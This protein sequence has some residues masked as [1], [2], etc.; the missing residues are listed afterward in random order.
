[1]ITFIIC[2]VAALIL[3]VRFVC[4]NWK[5]LTLGFCTL[6]IVLSLMMGVIA[7]G[8][9][10][11]IGGMVVYGFADK[12]WVVVKEYKL[13]SC[14]NSNAIS[15]YFFLGSGTIDSKDYYSAMCE[16]D[17][18]VMHSYRVLAEDSYIYYTENE[19]K[20]NIRANRVVKYEWLSK[21]FDVK[22]GEQIDYVF[23]IPKGS[24]RQVYKLN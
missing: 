20:L 16:Y 15:G 3:G 12:E 5:E 19:P 2:I 4:V 10:Y 7:V 23:Y 6:F 9:V 22:S 18:G 13:V 8:I 14:D 21:F 24:I 1:M 11:G 17:N